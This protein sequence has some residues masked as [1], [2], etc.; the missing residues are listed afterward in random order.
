MCAPGHLALREHLARLCT[1]ADPG[2]PIQLV[3][4]HNTVRKLTLLV[5]QIHIGI[6]RIYII[7]EHT[8]RKARLP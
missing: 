1:D 6:H 3:V 8:L 5:P 7:K 2:V 4:H